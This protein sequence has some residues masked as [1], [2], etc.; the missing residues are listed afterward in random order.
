M[1]TLWGIVASDE[2]GTPAAPAHPRRQPAAPSGVHTVPDESGRPTKQGWDTRS[3]D[4][5]SAPGDRVT[6]RNCR[7]RNDDRG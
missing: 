7:I 4:G 3:A 5:V 1:S 6:I 2:R